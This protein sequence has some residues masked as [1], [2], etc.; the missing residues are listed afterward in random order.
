[1]VE[2]EAVA[3]SG[4]EDFYSD[5]WTSTLFDSFVPAFTYRPHCTWTIKMSD[6]CYQSTSEIVLT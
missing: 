5:N 2:I 6:Y 3:V 4:W 1:M